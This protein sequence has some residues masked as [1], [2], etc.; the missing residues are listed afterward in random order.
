MLTPEEIAAQMT[1]DLQENNGLEKGLSFSEAMASN[2]AKTS[3]RCR[4]QN[5]NDLSISNVVLNSPAPIPNKVLK[6][7]FEQAKAPKVYY[8]P[9]IGPQPD[10]P[11]IPKETKPATPPT[12]GVTDR[13][14]EL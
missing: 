7:L 2:W 13:K 14:L 11:A 10:I 4:D 12:F 1:D 6:Y 9:S 8:P 5:L 3:R